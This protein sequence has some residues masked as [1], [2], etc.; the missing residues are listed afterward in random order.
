MHHWSSTQSLW[1][2]SLVETEMNAI[3]ERMDEMLGLM[4]MTTKCGKY[5]N[6]AH[7]HRL[8]THLQN[9]GYNALYGRKEEPTSLQRDQSRRRRKALL[10]QRKWTHRD[11]QPVETQRGKS[12]H[13]TMPLVVL[14]LRIPEQ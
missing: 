4:N 9:F 8:P 5:S 1:A 10:K 12:V 6:K 11:A 13:V 2:S 3:V 7:P 14:R